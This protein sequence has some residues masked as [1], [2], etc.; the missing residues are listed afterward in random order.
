MS[1]RHHRTYDFPAGESAPSKTTG[2]RR[3]PAGLAREVEAGARALAKVEQI[4]REALLDEALSEGRL[5][6]EA[7]E[8]AAR[9]FRASS[10]HEVRKYLTTL[11]PDPRTAAVNEAGEWTA[12]DE[13]AFRREFAAQ[14]GGR[15]ED[16]L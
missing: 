3:L 16:V 11:P 15:E 5:P 4:E 8:S 6:R 14:F 12:A 2:A 10:P 13:A 9:L 7:R 1:F